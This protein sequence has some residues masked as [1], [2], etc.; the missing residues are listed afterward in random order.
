[1]PSEIL[2]PPVAL[3]ASSAAMTSERTVVSGV[4]GVESQFMFGPDLVGP[5]AATSGTAPSYLQIWVCAVRGG[6]GVVALLVHLLL[7]L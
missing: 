2:A 1:M 6:M 3:I 4:S 5:S 7:L